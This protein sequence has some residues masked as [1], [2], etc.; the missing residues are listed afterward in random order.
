[1]E[2]EFET[3]FNAY[4]LR[5]RTIP[6]GLRVQFDVPLISKIDALKLAV[7]P[8]ETVWELTCVAKRNEEYGKG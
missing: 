3:S 8:E 5:I 2:S 1:M 6:D 7:A 4:N